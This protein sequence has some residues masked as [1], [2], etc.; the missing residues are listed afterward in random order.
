M[1]DF[2]SWRMKES[3]AALAQSGQGVGSEEQLERALRAAKENQ[4]LGHESMILQLLGELA[5]RTGDRQ[6]ATNYLEQ[7][8]KFAEKF[9]FYRML[10]QSMIDLAEL[11]RDD[12]DLKSAEKQCRHWR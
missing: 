5:M 10:G 8:C 3:S 11:Y 12:G 7:A 9:K 2:P 6:A 1:R 4:K